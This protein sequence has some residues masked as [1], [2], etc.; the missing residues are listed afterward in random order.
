MGRSGFNLYLG[1]T[2]LTNKGASQSSTNRR[3]AERPS[4]D[5]LHEGLRGTVTNDLLTAIPPQEAFTNS[6]QPTIQGILTPEQY[7]LIIGAMEKTGGASL[8]SNQIATTLS[9]RQT[10]FKV[11]DIKYIVTDLDNGTNPIKGGT[12]GSAGP[13]PIAEPFEIGPV[14]DVVP[15]ALADGQTINITATGTRR[16]FLGYREPKTNGVPLPKFRVRQASADVQMLDG[17]TLVLGAGAARD[18]RIQRDK[19]PVLGDLPYLGRFF[20]SESST[21]TSNA[22]FFFITPRLIDSAGNPVHSDE[23]VRFKRTN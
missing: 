17:Q 6:G 16:E 9:G 19:V 13:I 1:S 14:V 22:L 15:Y 20:R 5:L 3:L 2:F 10:Q 7:R 23:A 11:V 21:T 12:G 8:L 18:V 4:Q